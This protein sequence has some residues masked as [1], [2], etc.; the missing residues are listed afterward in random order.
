MPFSR[1]TT[2]LLRN[3]Y[4]SKIFTPK[5]LPVQEH[6]FNSPALI[7]TAQAM[8]DYLQPRALNVGVAGVIAPWFDV[9]RAII[10]L[11]NIKNGSLVGKDPFLVLVNPQ[12]S[13]ESAKIATR[14]EHSLSAP[15]T[16]CWVERP[17]KFTLHAYTIDGTHKVGD[18]AGEQAWRIHQLVDALNGVA[19]TARANKVLVNPS[20][21]QVEEFAKQANGSVNFA[22]KLR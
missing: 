13:A 8:H 22:P 15:N 12:I 1:F 14:I 5:A 3:A 19:L 16:I 6:E 9:N 17:E 4:A 18:V 10:A 7:A 21:E 20:L 11:F 2:E